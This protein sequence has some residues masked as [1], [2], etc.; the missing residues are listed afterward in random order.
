MSDNK[1]QSLVNSLEVLR[2]SVVKAENL[3]QQVDP[4]SKIRTNLSSYLAVCNK[5]IEFARMAQVASEGEHAEKALN[6]IHLIEKLADLVKQDAESLLGDNSP[7]VQFD[8]SN[9]H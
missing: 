9:A 1:I 3:V 7:S 8:R 5:Q 4:K 6:Y 2:E